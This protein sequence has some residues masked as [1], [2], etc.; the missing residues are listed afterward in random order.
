MELKWLNRSRSFLMA[1]AVC[2]ALVLPPA[3]MAQTAWQPVW[4]IGTFD[5]SSGEFNGGRG[6]IQPAYAKGGANVGGQDEEAEA[7]RGH[8][9]EYGDTKKSHSR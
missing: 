4:K 6:T 1:V 3:A 5:Q 2:F 9:G 8:D 7:S